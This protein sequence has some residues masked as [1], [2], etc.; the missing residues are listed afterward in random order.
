MGLPCSAEMRAVKPQQRRPSGGQQ[1][2]FVVSVTAEPS[3][4]FQLLVLLIMFEG[5]SGFELFT[6]EE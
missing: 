6:Q 4:L 2:P 5:L 1:W 3:S